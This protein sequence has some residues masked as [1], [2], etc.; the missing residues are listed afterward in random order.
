MR[1][2]PRVDTFGGNTAR[3]ADQQEEIGSPRR[4]QQQRRLGYNEGIELR[5]PKNRRQ[6]RH[7]RH[8]LRGKGPQGRNTTE[9][10]LRGHRYDLGD[11]Q[12]R[13]DCDRFYSHRD[14]RHG[15]YRVYI[16]LRDDSHHAV[17]GN[18]RDLRHRRHL[19]RHRD[20]R[21]HRRGRNSNQRAYGLGLR[22]Y[23][24]ARSRRQEDEHE[25]PAGGV[26]AG[27]NKNRTEA[28]TVKRNRKDATG[29]HETG[30][31]TTPRA[32]SKRGG[33]GGSTHSKKAQRIAKA[34]EELLR[35]Q[36]ELAAAKLAALETED[37]E[38]E[39]EEGDVSITEVNEKVSNW[40]D[41]N[42][43]TAEE[44][45]TPQQK[46]QQPA[47]PAPA[48]G[49]AD[50]SQLAEAITFA[51]KAAQRPKFIELPIFSGAHQE[52]LPFRAAYYETASS[53]SPIENTNR[54]RRN[55]KGRARE[56]VE[57]LLITSAAPEEVMKTLESRFGRPEAIAMVEMEALRGLPRL[58]E[59][60]R[61]ICIFSTKVSN[62]VATLKTLSCLNYLYNPEI[63]KSLV[64]KL[65]PTLKYRYFDYAA[66]Q[67]KSEPDLVKMERF[68]R[69]EAELCGPYALPEQVAAPPTV[70]KPQRVNNVQTY[71]PKCPACD[72]TGHNTQ[73]CAEF[74]KKD[75]SGR[76]DLAKARKLCFRCLRYRNKTHSCKPKPRGI[77][78]CK[79]FHN[80]LLHFERSTEKIPTEEQDKEVINSAWTA[81]R[82]QSYL[83]IVPLKVKG[84][85]GVVDTF[86][87][88]DDGS[89]VTLIDEEVAK[90]IGATGPVDP[91]RIET[92][93]ELKTSEAASR[94]VTFRLKGMNG[95]EERVQARTVKNL[96]VSSQKVSR[97]VVQDCKHLT[98]LMGHLTYDQAKPRLLIGQDNWHLLVTTRIRRGDH[99]QPVASL[100][101]LGWVL[102]G[103]QTRT[104]KHAIDYV[105]HTT[106]ESPEDDLE[107]MV[108]KYFEMDSLC[109][110]PKK[111]TTDP[112]QQAL[113]VLEKTTRRIGEGRYETGLLWKQEDI[114]FPN[115]YCNAVK[116]LE[117]IERKLDRDPKLK[118]KY[119]EQMEA[120]VAKG[121]A[122][123][124]PADKN[125]KK[126]WYLP[127]FAV[128]NPMKPEKLRVVHDA[129][130]K[131][132]GVALNDMLL[133]GPD[134]MQSLPGVVMRFRQHQIA[135][136]ADIKE[137]FMQVKLREAD[138]DSLRYVWRGNRR[139]DQAPEE[140]RMTSLIFGAS[141]SP[142]TAIYVKNLNAKEHE[143]THPEAAAAIIEKHYVDDYLD[144]FRSLED[145][146]RI[147]KGVRDIHAKACFEL[148]QWKSNSTLLLQELGEEELI[149]DMELY[150]T[151]EK[152]ERV[153][154][155][156]WKLNTDELTF[157]LNLAR[158]PTT[159]LEGET[160]TKREALRIVMSLFDPLGFASP[161]TIRAKQLLQEVWRRG[162]AWDDPIDEDLAEQWTTWLTHLQKLRDVKI[163]RR[164]LNYSDAASIQL[165]IF[166]DA[167]ESA[168][169]A[170]LYWRT[171]TPDGEVKLSLIVAKAKVAP[172]KLTSIPRLELQAAVMGTR[173]ADSVIEEHERKPDCK[174]F[175]TDSKT[176]LTWIRTGSRTYKP[177][178]AHRLAAIEE[179]TKVNEWRWVP[180]KL[181]VADDATRDVPLTFDKD[182]RWYKGPD[183]LY[184]EEDQWPVETDTKKIEDTSGEEKVNHVANKR[185]LRLTEGLPEASRF[186][187]WHRLRYTTA[188]V[189]L[190]IE[191]C[192]RNK[193]SVNYR[194]TKKNKE[195]DPNWNKI[196]RKTSS[197]NETQKK[198]TTKINRKF[199]PVSAENLKQAEELLMRASQ[200]ESFAEE[201]ANLR[202]GKPVN[203]ESR[204]HQLSVTC[205]DGALRLRSRIKAVKYMPEDFKSPMIIDGDHPIV[206]TWIRAIH[207]QLHHAGVE[208]TV[209]EC[210]QQYWV[211]RLRPTTRSVLRQCLFCRMKT[212]TPPH[213]R[214]GDLPQCRLAHH[215]RPFTYTGV[216]YFGP[217]SVTVGR[218][219][220]KR[221]VAIFTCL[222][223]RA[224][225]LE[226]AGSLSTD[227]AVMAVRRM[228]SRRGCPTEIWSD[229]GT[230]LKGAEKELRQQID[231]ATAEEA[232]KRTIAWRFIPPGAPF[233]G[234]AWERMVRSVKT[235]LAATLHERHPTEE[236]LSTLLAEVEY[237]VN[238]R[239]LTHVSVSPEDPEAL[240]PNHFLLGGQGRVPLPGSF[241]DKDVASRSSWRAAQRLADL[242]WTRWVR[243]YLPELQHRREPHGR[244][245]AVQVNDLVQIV[246]ANLPRN[247][248]VRGRV[249]DTYPGPDGVVRAVDIRTKGGVLRRPVRKLVILPLHD[250]GPAHGGDATSSHGGRDVRDSVN[251]LREKV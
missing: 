162:T 8:T 88:L 250:G 224:I 78:N 69:R 166:T 124:A 92:I 223:T 177:Y 135:V 153:L 106:E 119:N 186:S 240:T 185:E 244:G 42:K 59:S 234:G 9:A 123:R 117:N 214:T 209:N 112:E 23:H 197:T 169:S 33:G 241:T 79:Y 136:T 126:T 70:R 46:T 87:L 227:S 158:V 204:L 148:K 200:E 132:R 208:A 187:N 50:F 43:N 210:R 72:E 95:H 18:R 44:D 47:Q 161:V 121:Y 225:H 134:L 228:I 193:E 16:R 73:D 221:Y 51:V 49:P 198:T 115:N 20:R 113:R 61:D 174:V 243:E 75:N 1:P 125:P 155:V 81:K 213:P 91:L 203:K 109:I 48:G 114:S 144:S 236:V 74:K 233:M 141:S 247:V 76:W 129:A 175:W 130:A 86:A 137:M 58:T 100:T 12:Q 110:V 122:E 11:R 229:N 101:P 149:E 139:D 24:A 142:S 178:V 145:A 217:L 35:L 211:L 34:K 170:V 66:S 245:P 21:H 25:P 84:P 19:G 90:E 183:F 205:V 152:T 251:S 248:W 53:Y 179:S 220:Q 45:A 10:I 163:P 165:H 36:V 71:T 192:R 182:H 219:R 54:L 63:C 237:T 89:T 99:H 39:D 191:L 13:R 108:K 176:V 4:L 94:R 62:I 82:K 64:D 27:V 30:G 235:A 242:F 188:R 38:D 133:K 246:D 57:G 206:K 37:T 55:L 67:Q 120:L 102:H 218:T 147:A 83:K 195:Q 22:C 222:T 146:V 111:P 171:K 143:A 239:P 40:L 232:A 32:P 41:T 131:T 2:T 226:I 150:K 6:K 180:T 164:Y 56:A 5:R 118:Q 65:T 80:R 190:F 138:R 128:I 184:E 215:K 29:P 173:L 14:Y 168:Y 93:N 249:I 196:A 107:A 96:Q 98:D 127:H 238:S 172:L 230:N 17:I 194:R 116:R 156:I 26:T 77:D 140:Y 160:P 68:L 202:S 154:G 28:S 105:S 181:N 159:L 212:G 231:E 167:S 15:N 97:E 7:A 85:K 31:P 151:E 103:S 104:M 201:I 60:P 199:L 157:N 216:D 189:L 3:R 207:Q 52:W